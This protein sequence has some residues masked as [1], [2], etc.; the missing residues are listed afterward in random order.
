MLGTANPTHIDAIEQHCQLRGVHLD[1]PTIMSEPRSAKSAALEPL[2]IEN[3][4][5]TIPKQDLAAVTPTP[6]KHEQMPGEQVH[7][8]LPTDN[9][10]QAIVATAKIDWL[11]CEV[12]PNA[13]WQR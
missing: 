4:A 6:Q 12:D 9:A 8:P 2:V 11:D 1:R 5:A 3:E 7:A 13:R 10:A